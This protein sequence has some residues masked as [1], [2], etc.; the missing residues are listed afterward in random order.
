MI[1]KLSYIIFLWFAVVLQADADIK[2]DFLVDST[3]VPSFSKLEK[4]T[5]EVISINGFVREQSSGEPIPYANVYLAESNFGTSTND[6]GYFLIQNVPLG[7]YQLHVMMMGY[8][9]Y[10]DSLDLHITGHKRID[11]RLTETILVTEGVTVSAERTRHQKSV[12]TSQINL[13]TKLLKEK[14][15]CHLELFY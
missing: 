12:Q 6:D 1:S 8:D 9:E 13:D 7:K 5:D 14:G 11:I 3:A 4:F 2:D 15:S 10:A